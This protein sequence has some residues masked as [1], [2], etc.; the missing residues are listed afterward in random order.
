MRQQCIT[1]C[2]VVGVKALKS[3]LIAL[4]LTPSQNDGL[5]AKAEAEG[6][7][8]SAY[9]V[10]FVN[11]ALADSQ[12][13]AP[14][15]TEKVRGTVKVTARLPPDAYNYLVS[16]A[17]QQGAPV[18]TWVTALLCARSRSAPQLVPATRRTAFS[19]FKQVRGMSV[20]INQIAHAVNKGVL[21]GAGAELSA[22]E[23]TALRAEVE[24]LRKELTALAAGQMKFQIEGGKGSE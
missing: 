12:P 22:K 2:E 14:S 24:A 19:L 17:A 23:L 11:H 6:M 1:F 8:V 13:T 21:T 7:T 4:R 18:S 9:L 16:E 10:R 15:V 5:K 20:N 3:K